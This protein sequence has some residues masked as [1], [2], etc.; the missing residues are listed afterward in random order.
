M[1]TIHR[2]ICICPLS[3]DTHLFVLK[4]PPHYLQQH[5]SPENSAVISL[6]GWG[7][8]TLDLVISCSDKLA[9]WTKV[10]IKTNQVYRNSESILSVGR[11]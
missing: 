11:C 1:S 5:G 2:Y 8:I 9:V 6:K 4:I 10:G 3:V 7:K